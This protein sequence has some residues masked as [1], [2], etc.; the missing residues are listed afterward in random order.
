ME[1]SVSKQEHSV[2]LISRRNMDICGVKDVENFDEEGATLV[3]LC[4][5]LSVEGKNIKI[6][7]LDVERGVVKIEGQ[8]DALFYSE[9][10]E[11]SKRSLFGKRI[12]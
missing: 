7:V 6:S 2:N 9:I 8:I 1:T 10:G 4:G 3:T 12:G 11:N 5:R